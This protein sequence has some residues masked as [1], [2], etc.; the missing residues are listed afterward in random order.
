MPYRLNDAEKA[1]FDALN[2]EVKFASA[3][4]DD[5]IEQDF[6]E[7]L[8]KTKLASET[9][10]LAAFID[11]DEVEKAFNQELAKLQVD[12]LPIAMAM[13]IGLE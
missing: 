4:D 5:V 9:V 13:A 7:S 11:E 8:S 12:W 6:F 1:F 3:F 2:G 10:K